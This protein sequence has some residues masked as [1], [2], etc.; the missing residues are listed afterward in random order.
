MVELIVIAHKVEPFTTS[1]SDCLIPR[2]KVR[3][4]LVDRIDNIFLAFGWYVGTLTRS[5]VR[6]LVEGAPTL[7]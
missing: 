1:K 7:G 4:T 2:T 3:E 6:L 5:R